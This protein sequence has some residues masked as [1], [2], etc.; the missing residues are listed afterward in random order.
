M[1]VLDLLKVETP[2]KPSGQVHRQSL[3]ER[4]SVLGPLLFRLLELDSAA[5]GQPVR[6]GNGGVHRRGSRVPGRIDDL[7]HVSRDGLVGA[8][9]SPNEATFFTDLSSTLS[10]VDCAF[11]RRERRRCCLDASGQGD[12]YSQPFRLH[13]DSASIW[14][15][16]RSVSGRDSVSGAA[17]LFLAACSSSRVKRRRRRS[18]ASGAGLEKTRTV[19]NSEA[20]PSGLP[21]LLSL[22]LS[23]ISLCLIAPVKRESAPDCHRR[24][25]GTEALADG[26][27]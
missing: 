19:P 4:G 20:T 26:Q 24:R 18:S 21:R 23:F 2:W 6:G 25:Q 12:V 15:S 8:L 9:C 17:R 16:A 1:H 5:S 10:N 27:V 3:D 22:S 14:S 11:A 13:Q 7:R